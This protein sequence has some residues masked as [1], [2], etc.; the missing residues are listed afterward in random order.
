MG[1]E[2]GTIMHAN[3]HNRIILYVENLDPCKICKYIKLLS[4][5]IELLLYL[6]PKSFKKETLFNFTEEFYCKK[7]P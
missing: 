5:I 4:I 3:I 1:Q 2:L 7:S 6:R